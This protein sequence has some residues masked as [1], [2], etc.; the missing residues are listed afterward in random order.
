M[1]DC[2]SHT[3]NLCFPLILLILFILLTTQI[4]KWKQTNR[5]KTRR[6]LKGEGPPCPTLEYSTAERV[7][8]SRGQ[9]QPHWTPVTPVPAATWWAR[10]AAATTER[11]AGPGTDRSK[12]HQHVSHVFSSQ[13]SNNVQENGVAFRHK[14][15]G[16][17]ETR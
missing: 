6:V 8:V 12:T 3:G 7:T 9:Q 5:C 16:E 15:L 14:L 10:H 4:L 2:D 13:H 17:R 1:S 11:P